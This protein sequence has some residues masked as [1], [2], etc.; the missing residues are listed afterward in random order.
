MSIQPTE[1]QQAH[2]II[3]QNQLLEHFGS[4]INEGIDV[5]IIMAGIGSATA[6]MI[7]GAYGPAAVAPWF[8]EQAGMCAVAFGRR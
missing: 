4:L 3:V 2:A 5:R 1:E 6:A 7:A 8:E